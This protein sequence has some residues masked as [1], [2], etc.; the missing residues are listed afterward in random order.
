MIFIGTCGDAVRHGDVDIDALVE[1][2]PEVLTVVAERLGTDARSLVERRI[3]RLEAVF[4]SET[5]PVVEVSPK[6]AELVQ[7][8]DEAV[9]SGLVDI[10]DVVELVDPP[11]RDP[12]DEEE[13]GQVSTEETAPAPAEEP[14]SIEATVVNIEDAF[15]SGIVELGN[16]VGLEELIPE[17]DD[18]EETDPA[19]E[20]RPVATPLSQ[21]GEPDEAVLS[22]EAEVTST[23]GSFS[24]EEPE[25]AA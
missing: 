21:P 16:I 10:G 2:A 14:N 7:P 3:E 6:V 13:P 17:L 19:T 4:K 20:T 5:Q 22:G 12:I 24:T 8:L 15:A 1:Q 11:L 9:T 25:A 18:D 23:A